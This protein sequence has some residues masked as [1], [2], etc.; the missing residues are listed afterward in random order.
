MN[1]LGHIYFSG[2]IN[3]TLFILIAISV[4]LGCQEQKKSKE[5]QTKRAD[6]AIQTK[7]VKSDDNLIGFACFE[8][9]SKSRS[10]KLFSELLTK[11]DY[12][13][14]RNRLVNKNAAEKYLA[15]IVCLKLQEKKMIELTAEEKKQIKSNKHSFDLVTIC[16]GCTDWEE[17]TILELFE[18]NQ[19]FLKEEI[20]A[21]LKE[22]IK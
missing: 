18:T 9:G 10:V 17:R 21:W 22:M 13:A 19:T 16:S 12:T 6:I 4:S 1:Y 8:G 15:S 7:S 14:V 20:E 3:K 11:K 5:V 2:I